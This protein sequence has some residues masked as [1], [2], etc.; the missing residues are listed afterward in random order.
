M[1]K[2]YY[3]T[4]PYPDEEL[5]SVIARA[6]RHVGLSLPGFLF[7]YFGN[8]DVNTISAIQYLVCHV[9]ELTG[10][11]RPRLLWEHTL[12]PYL[13]SGM[14]AAKA[15]ALE[16][17]A[18][19]YVEPAV[20]E[21]HLLP[22][23]GRIDRRYCNKCAA[24]DVEKYG[25]DYWHRV[26]LLPG[27]LIC[28]AHDEPL[29]VVSQRAARLSGDAVIT[30]SIGLAMPG[31]SAGMLINM[32]ASYSTQ[33]RVSQLAVEAL[34][35]SH[36]LLA[37]QGGIPQIEDLQNRVITKGMVSALGKR[38]SAYVGCLLPG[39]GRDWQDTSGKSV[40]DGLTARQILLRVV[41]ETG[42]VE[43]TS[44]EELHRIAVSGLHK[45]LRRAGKQKPMTVHDMLE[46]AGCP[47]RYRR[48]RRGQPPLVGALI[49]WF[50]C[51]PF[52]KKRRE[53]RWVPFLGTDRYRPIVKQHFPDL[54]I[55]YDPDGNPGENATDSTR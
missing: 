21:S 42:V 9:S 34:A 50:R 28:A 53:T 46:A 4:R 48:R 24:A 19:S 8:Y 32:D 49:W 38:Y 47:P 44:E 43:M 55:I 3:F 17:M 31:D 30:P 37:N 15:Q 13:V 29:K 16:T 54:L 35:Y 45:F 20:A 39:R 12:F 40:L 51:S 52:S 7:W 36:E 26:H 2:R 18:L 22:S 33:K 11:G 25:E 27:V 10:L 5:G 1:V 41:Q 14:S 6:Y 23:I